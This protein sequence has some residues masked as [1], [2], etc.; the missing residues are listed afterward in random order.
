MKFFYWLYSVQIKKLMEVWGSFLIII[1][2]TF[3]IKELTRTLFYPWRRDIIKPVQP[4][5]QILFESWSLNLMSRL[6]GAL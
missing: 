3:S 4:P 6:I 1:A 5:L 2:D